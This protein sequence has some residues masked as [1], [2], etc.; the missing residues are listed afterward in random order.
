MRRIGLF[1][2]LLLGF[3]MQAA[4][5]VGGELSYR[6]LG[7]SNYEL[8]L[9]IYR[10][11]ASNGAPFD[12][13][14][15]I[16]IFNGSNQV[17]HNLQV[18]L[19]Q[20]SF[21]PI[22][23]PNNCTA[24]PSFVCTQEGIYLDTVNLPAGGGP[25]TVS[26]QRCC[27]NNSIDNI[28]NPRL[29]GN[30]YTI[31]IPA[32]PACN[33]SP[34]FSAAPPVALCLNVP[35]NID[36]GAIETD[37]DSLYYFLCSPLHGG[38]NQVNTTGPNSP[39]PDTASAPPYALVPFS[40]TYSTSYPIA[41][42][43]AFNLDPQT[44]MLS[45]KPNQ[46]GQYVFAVCV[47]EWRNGVLLS[48]LRRDFQF[49]VTAAC[50][51]TTADFDEQDLDPYTLCS[52]KTIQFNEDCINTSRYFWDFGV[53]L[54]N[55]DTSNLPNPVYTF[56]DTGVYQVMLIAEPGSSC[57]DT[58]I[59]E[60]KVFEGLNVG[61]DIGGQACF[62]QHS[63]NFTP[64]GNFGP[65]A[66]F[67]WNFGGNTTSGSNTSTL[68]NPSGIVYAQSGSY[69][70]TLEIEDGDCKDNYS[71]SVHLYPRPILK[72]RLDANSGC[73]PYAVSFRDSSE[74]A[75]T[76]IHFWDFGDGFTSSQQNPVHLYE[77]PGDYFVYHRLIT[78]SA[79]KDTL[80][81]QSSTAIRIHPTP[82]PGMIIM[83]EETTIFNPEFEITLT[84]ENY[85]TSSL[86][87]PD[88]RK[89]I[90]PGNNLVYTARDTGIQRFVHIVENEF[91]CSDTVQV[92][93]YVQQPFRLYIP[94]AFT[95]NGDGLNDRFSYSILG[96]Q[97]FKIRILNRWGQLVFQTGDPSYFWNGRMNNMGDVLPGGVYTYVIEV[98][99]KEDLTSVVKRGTVSLIR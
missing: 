80:E 37:G 78:T 48:T 3:G 12:D 94:N 8:R 72:H 62:D 26:H 58:M 65:D 43:P 93:T 53:P 21:L 60:F 5:L 32:S 10:D 87:F 22:N 38:G 30:T 56:P 86:L 75:G 40:N 13:P 20:S 39:R 4:H 97:E 64:T 84:S 17:V 1:L 90:D 25:Y 16:T 67:N 68:K 77:N 50:V 57:A 85:S 36:M 31:N 47:Q 76:A 82:F 70:V 74:Y 42:S 73:V 69:L 28:P 27:R 99:Q 45:G 33:S 81:E 52:G 23:A 88:G 66:Q 7:G 98:I 63:F 24:L 51:R 55:S 59:R 89:V 35:V 9:I 41:S 18:P 71:D 6:C 92:E 46:V 15:I 44:G 91:G 96:V 95:P 29:W 83:P 79:C 19:H 34:R 49:N 54:T 14:A 2:L 11:C 61:F